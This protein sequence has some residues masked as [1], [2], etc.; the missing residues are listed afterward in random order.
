MPARGGESSRVLLA[1][2]DDDAQGQSLEVFRDYEIDRWILEEEGWSDLAARGF[3]PP[4]RF[5]GLR[6]S[7]M[8]IDY[9]NHYTINSSFGTR[10]SHELPLPRE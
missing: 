4:R 5:T 3:D 1:C 10:W 2:T 9:H 8:S 7:T 6:R